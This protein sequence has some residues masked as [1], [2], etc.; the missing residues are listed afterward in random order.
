MVLPQIAFCANYEENI[1]SVIFNAMDC[2]LECNRRF[3]TELRW[4]KG[5]PEFTLKRHPSFHDKSKLEL[6]R[7]HG[8]WFEMNIDRIN[9]LYT[10]IKSLFPTCMFETYNGFTYDITINQIF[11]LGKDVW[12]NIDQQSVFHCPTPVLPENYLPWAKAVTHHDYTYMMSDSASTYKAGIASEENIANLRK[13]LDPQICTL[14]YNFVL[15][16]M[17]NR[18]QDAS[19]GIY[20]NREKWNTLEEAYK[21]FR[22]MPTHHGY[23]ESG[24]DPVNTPC[25]GFPPHPKKIGWKEG[26]WNMEYMYS[27]SRFLTK[28]EY[29]EQEVTLYK[30]TYQGNT[31]I[32]HEEIYISRKDVDTYLA[33]SIDTG[34]IT[35][36]YAL[37]S[38]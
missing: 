15:G 3:N 22:I 26:D 24:K 21:E 5:Y 6:S 25:T 35:V 28:E 16:R 14:W 11:S 9:N 17:R 4:F 31:H 18:P 19:F 29:W 13:G 2:K 27:N 20:T 34:D 1:K 33:K 23:I 37:A 38:H 7:A 10:L 12:T 8:K 30:N 32:L 36:T